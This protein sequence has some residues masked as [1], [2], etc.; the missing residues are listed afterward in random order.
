VNKLNS[1]KTIRIKINGENRPFIKEP[2]IEEPPSVESSEHQK[3][4][5]AIQEDHEAIVETAASQEAEESFDWILP[6][7]DPSENELN[8]YQTEKSSKKRNGI[9]LPALSKVEKQNVSAIKSIALSV[10]FAI[11]LGTGFGFI[12]LKLVITDSSKTKAVVTKSV[13]AAKKEETPANSSKSSAVLTQKPLT[14]YMVQG[15]VFSKKETANTVARQ[16]IEKGIPAETMEWNGKYYLFLGVADSI[17]HARSLGSLYQNKGFDGVFPK[18]ITIPEK[19]FSNLSTDEKS[20]IENAT[21]LV[22]LLATLSSNTLTGGTISS[23]ERKTLSELETKLKKIN[24]N[25][26]K[27]K[28]INNLNVEMTGALKQITDYQQKKDHKLLEKAQQHLLTFLADY[29]AY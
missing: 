16:A 6:Q 14:T 20:L 2:V 26:I 23:N 27:N 15:G 8:L 29:N 19:K 9:R 24:S 5:D 17:E 22:P 1:G 4:F 25:G 28:E 21:V 13:P 12:M 11:L 18:T 3:Q 10:C 7:Q